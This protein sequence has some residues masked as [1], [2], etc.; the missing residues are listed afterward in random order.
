[1]VSLPSKTPATLET[2]LLGFPSS[3]CV[4]TWWASSLF[5]PGGGITVELSDSFLIVASTNVLVAC[6]H[7]G[8]V[9]LT[10]SCLRE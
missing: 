3:G 7:D 8:Q 4:D 2:I 6:P 10:L 9:D 5:G 1:V